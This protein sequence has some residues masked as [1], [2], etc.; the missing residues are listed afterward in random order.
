MKTLKITWI[1]IKGFILTLPFY[2]MFSPIL[3]I[4]GNTWYGWIACT[5]FTYITFFLTIMEEYVEPRI[6]KIKKEEIL[7]KLC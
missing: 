3:E 1:Y 2:I 4:I 7:K 6:N 5:V